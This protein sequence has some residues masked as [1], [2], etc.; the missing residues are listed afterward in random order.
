MSAFVKATVLDGAFM[1]AVVPHMLKQANYPLAETYLVVDPRRTFEGKYSSRT[2]APQEFDQ[3]VE[4]LLRR[5][6]VQRVVDV[7]Y[8]PDVVEEVMTAFFG[9]V[10]AKVPT[11]ATSG[12]PIYPTLYGIWKAEN[13]AVLQFDCDM[14]FYTPEGFSWV[15]RGLE[16]MEQDDTVA[17]MMAHPGPPSGPP[18]G[19][20]A[21]AGETSRG[22][23]PGTSM[24]LIMGR[25][26]S[27]S[28][29][30]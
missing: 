12:G 4:E 24:G 25:R 21:C 20:R 11:H 17:M 29:H 16:I 13:D 30:S 3:T 9:P 7:D 10:G 5:G 6:V 22:K 2:R 19:S 23:A 26:F 1:A 28:S 27:S 14:L 18:C 15:A 8:A